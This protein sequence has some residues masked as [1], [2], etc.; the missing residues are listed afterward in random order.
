LR[1][2]RWSAAVGIVCTTAATAQ[3]ELRWQEL[4]AARMVGT[5]P[6]SRSRATGQDAIVIEDSFSLGHANQARRRH[7]CARIDAMIA[8]LPPARRGEVTHPL[9]GREIDGAEGESCSRTTSQRRTPRVPQKSFLDERN[10]PGFRR[11]R[12]NP[13]GKALPLKGPGLGEISGP[14][15]SSSSRPKDHGSRSSGPGKS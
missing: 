7:R 9:R 10:P 5:L 2:L 13:P 4:E 14:S 1:N 11:R 12:T 8:E 6:W 15:V 3:R